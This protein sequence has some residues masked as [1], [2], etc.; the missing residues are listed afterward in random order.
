MKTIWTGAIGFG[1][2][3]IPVKLFSATHES[4]LDLDMLDK[5]D[6]SNIKFHRVNEKTGKEVAWDNIVKGY[7]IDD[8]YVILED[9]DFEKA[10]AKKTKTIEILQFVQEDEI[11]SVYFETPYYIQPDKSGA[12]AYALLREAL[13]KSKKVAV[14]NYVLRNKEALAILKP[15]GN[16]I[17]LNKI[18]FQEEIIDADTLDL[19][20]KSQI[21]EGEMKM[22]LSLIDQLTEEFDI[23]KYKDTYTAELLKVI[24]A[25]AKGTVIKTKSVAAKPTAT[26]DLMAQLKASLHP[27][28]TKRTAS[29]R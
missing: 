16:V 17:V 25:K 26:K 6:H 5:K 4:R 7:K 1:L 29:A 23:S 13:R 9:K 22:A 15:I 18:R 14:A 3:N 28:S 11:D 19:P 12:R 10:N 2:V 21:K 8:A 20:A 27:V 24:K